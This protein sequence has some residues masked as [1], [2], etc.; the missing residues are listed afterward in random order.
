MQLRRKKS[1]NFNVTKI[2]VTS[3]VARTGLQGARARGARVPTFVVTKSSRSESHLT[4]I[5]LRQN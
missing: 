5:S 1:N 3:G 2:C 4:D